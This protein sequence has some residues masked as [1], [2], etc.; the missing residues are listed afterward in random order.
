MKSDKKLDEDALL[1]A[2]KG[3]DFM[4]RM[5][6][7][8]VGLVSEM[9]REPEVNVEKRKYCERFLELL[10]DMEVILP[11]RRF[12]NTLLDNEQVVVRLEM[13]KLNGHPDCSL[14]CEMLQ[15]L[16]YYASFEIDDHSGNPLTQKE[17]MSRH[18]RR[19]TELQRSVFKLYP[20]LHKFCTSSVSRIDSREMLMKHFRPLNSKKLHHVCAML[21]MVE[22][23]PQEGGKSSYDKRLL[24]E[25]I[26]SRHEKRLTQL[27]K[28][29][30]M[31]LYPTEELLWDENVIPMSFYDGKHCLALPKLNLQFLTLHDYL[32]R[33][34]HLFRLEAAY[35]IREELE[36]VV[37]RLKP[38]HT[39]DTQEVNFGGWAKFGMPITNFTR[40]E[41]TQPRLGEAHP[42]K[43]SGHVTVTLSMRPEL[44]EEW[45]NLRRFDTG[46]LLT[47]RPS[48]DSVQNLDNEADF[49]TRFGVVYVRGIEFEGKLDDE[50]KLIEDFPDQPVKF[51]GDQRTF[52]VLMDPCQYQIDMENHE[53]GEEDVYETFNVIF[54]RSPKVN[55]F[56]AVL[57][58]IRDLMNSEFSVPEWLHDIILGYGDPASAHYS[59]MPHVLGHTTGGDEDDDGWLDFNDT[60]LD[61]EHLVH[62]FPNCRVQLRRQVSRDQ[63]IPPFRLRF[64][65]LSKETGEDDKET[66]EGTGT[67]DE[68]KNTEME[69]ES[70]VEVDP[71]VIPNRGPFPFDAP[72]KNAI[73]FT[74]TQIEAIKSGT[75]PAFYFDLHLLWFSDRCWVQCFYVNYC[76][77]FYSANNHL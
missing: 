57:E 60:F 33:N 74:P 6:Q 14:L 52:R 36:D 38:W 63:M 72:K 70:V 61:Y 34:F 73:R 15:Y 77:V 55:N 30:N 1:K 23:L 54:R 21:N 19:V 75:S 2:K 45:E 18:Y 7:Q 25:M 50:G 56:K 46:F 29:N 32:L 59:N 22:S 51:K 27:Q 62:G 5:L 43:V 17:M 26:T 28:I 40:F 71:H 3:R 69:M 48:N 37:S 76:C 16:K 49:Q 64:K 11:T 44:K 53:N 9:E 35:E 67:E 65:Q 20:E 31:P 47:L 24:L 4:K 66:V 12:F 8:F 68:R 13:S 39:R 10:I 42:A 41:V 58:T